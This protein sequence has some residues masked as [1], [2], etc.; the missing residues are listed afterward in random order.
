MSWIKLDEGFLDHPKFLAAGPLAGYLA[1]AAIAWS[2][3]NCTDGKIPEAQ[4]ERLVNLRGFAHHMWQGEIVGGG[5]DA[6]ALVLAEE[7]VAVGLWKRVK[8]GYMIHDYLDWQDSAAKV[9]REREAARKRMQRHRSRDV[10]PN[11][12]GTSGEVTPMF[13]DGSAQRVERGE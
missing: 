6:D 2:R 5:D 10:R 3:R 13:A 4:V 7:L 12:E 9:R 1:I 8:D 11:T